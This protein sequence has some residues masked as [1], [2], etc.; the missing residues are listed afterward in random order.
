MAYIEALNVELFH[1]VG[2]IYEFMQ[3]YILLHDLEIHILNSCLDLLWFHQSKTPL[4][5]FGFF[6]KLFI[7]CCA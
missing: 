6:D 4:E 2:A 3:L 5:V 7:N 1:A